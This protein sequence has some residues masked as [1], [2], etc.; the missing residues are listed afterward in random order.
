MVIPWHSVYIYIYIYTHI[1]LYI[2]IYI[3]IILHTYQSIS[4]MMIKM[5][6]SVYGCVSNNISSLYMSAPH[7]HAGRFSHACTVS[8]GNCQTYPNDMQNTG[9]QSIQK[10]VIVI[11]TIIHPLILWDKHAKIGYL[12]AIIIIIAAMNSWSI[13]RKKIN[14]ND[15]FSGSGRPLACPITFLCTRSAAVAARLRGVSVNGIRSNKNILKWILIWL[16][17]IDTPNSWFPTK[18]NHSCGSFGT[19]ILSHD[20]LDPHTCYVLNPRNDP[21]WPTMVPHGMHATPEPQLCILGMYIH[22]YVYVSHTYVYTYI[23]IYIHMYIYVTHSNRYM[24]NY[25]HM[26]NI[27]TI[28]YLYDI[29]YNQCVITIGTQV[30]LEPKWP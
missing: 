28:T 10:S 15:R 7:I 3:H 24:Y 21:G 20:P 18:Y 30:D 8:T 5:I 12:S 9:C 16:K 26:I 19:L 13:W 27:H 23:Y 4:V 1:Y 14:Y 17:N 11:V 2:Y 25:I 29:Y 6:V 22:M